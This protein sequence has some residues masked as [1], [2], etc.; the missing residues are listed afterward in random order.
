MAYDGYRSPPPAEQPGF[1]EYSDPRVQ[2]PSAYP[3]QYAPDISRARPRE[4][5]SVRGDDFASDT[6][7]PGQSQHTINEAVSSSFQKADPS[8]Y[9]APE[10]LAQ[11]TE[12]VIK[13]LK[14]TGLEGGTP[15]PQQHQ[16]PPPPPPLAQSPPNRSGSSP[17]MTTRSAYGPPSPRLKSETPMYSPPAHTSGSN[18]NSQSL[19]DSQLAHGSD[20]KSSTPPTQNSDPDHRRP[21]GPA[22][23]S[24]SMEETTLEKIWGQLFDETGNPTVRLGQFLRGLAIHIVGPAVYL[25]PVPALLPSRGTN[26]TYVDRGL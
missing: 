21:K 4:H 20:R 9:V 26:P 25:S 19:R 7:R 24:T 2:Y 1:F 6:A 15:A 14:T 12:N 3:H 16:Q 11:I 22:R 5:S 8:T 18:P 13:Q 23:L 17:V 10:L